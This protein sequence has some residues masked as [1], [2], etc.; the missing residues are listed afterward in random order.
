MAELPDKLYYSIR[1]VA[2]HTGV[3]PHVLR[4]WESEF[5]TLKPKRARSGARNYRKKDIDEILT[6]RSL[7]QEEGYRIE[8]A[9]KHLREHKR[10]AAAKEQEQPQESLFEGQ[11]RGKR[12]AHLRRELKEVMDLLKE[13]KA[14][15]E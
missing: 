14:K 11:N 7:L 10:G 3:E 5:P 9:R 8:G 6:I 4:Y 13:M 12:I 15:G 1:E 2:E